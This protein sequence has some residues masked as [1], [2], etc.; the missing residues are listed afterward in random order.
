MILIAVVAL[1]LM[2]GMPYLMDNSMS[3]VPSS[4]LPPSPIR[5]LSPLPSSLL[6]FSTPFLLSC[7]LTNKPSLPCSS[8]SRNEEGVRRT[9]EEE[10]LERWGERGESAAEFRHGRVDGG[11]DVGGE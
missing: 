4:P 5:F 7:W 10:H 6:P 2:F 11:E 3:T 8:G 9:A 1:A